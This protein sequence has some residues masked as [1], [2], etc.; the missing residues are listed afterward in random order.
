MR[1]LK[2]FGHR[3]FSSAP[4]H[5]FIPPRLLSARLTGLSTRTMVGARSVGGVEEGAAVVGN[6]G[7]GDGVEGGRNGGVSICV[8]ATIDVGGRDDAVD[9]VCGG[10]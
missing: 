2:L 1:C 9:G 7:Y 8:E 5:V 10:G 3:A 6:S 4:R